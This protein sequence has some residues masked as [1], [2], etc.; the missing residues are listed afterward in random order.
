MMGC[1]W[2]KGRFNSRDVSLRAENGKNEVVAAVVVVVGVSS[3]GEA[4]GKGKR[5]RWRACKGEKRRE[6][7]WREPHDSLLS[8]ICGNAKHWNK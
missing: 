5:E 3:V 4:D 6:V 8:P 2:L 1:R 7:R